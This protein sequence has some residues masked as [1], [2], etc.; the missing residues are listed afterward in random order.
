MR[1]GWLAVW[2]CLFALSSLVSAQTASNAVTKDPQAV[3]ILTQS[4]RAVDTSL[5]LSGLQDYSGTGTITFNW[6]GEQSPVPVIVRGMG[7]TNF[8]LD[9]S[10]PDGMRTYAVSNY[11]GIVISQN[12]SRN[13]AS[14]P[15]LFT[16]G[17]L[18]IPSFRA[19]SVLTDTTTSITTTGIST[20]SGQQE[21][22]VHC[23][24]TLYTPQSGKNGPQN[25]GVFDL[26]IDPST[27]FVVALV[28]T[29]YANS[30]INAPVVHELDFSSYGLFGGLEV[31]LAVTEKVNG[32][33]TWSINLTSV[34]FNNGFSTAE[35][36]P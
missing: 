2:V 16:A 23:V 24:S 5:A 29:I 14:G 11:S 20:W 18:T 26:Y 34:S 32:Q 25:F 4:L 19:A 22:K 9:A 10:L 27:F 36:T 6:P 1:R 15:N 3:S 8:R 31:P 17:S 35:F 28:E 7:L 30:N 12:G 13:T 33:T 21:Y